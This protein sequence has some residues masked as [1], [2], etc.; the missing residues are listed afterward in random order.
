MAATNKNKLPS[1]IKPMLGR[2]V[3]S[4]FDSPKH[5]FELKW[6]G[7]RGL[8]FVEGGE[9]RLLSRNGR[10]ITTQFPELGE[11]AKQV[12]ADGV[13]LDGEIVCLDEQ[14]RPSFSRLQQRLQSKRVA[15]PRINPAHFIAFDILYI[16]GQSVMKQPLM[17]R[18]NLLGEVLN[19]TELIQACLFVEDEGEPFFQATCELGLEGIMAKDKSSPYLPGRRSPAWQKI[20]RVNSSWVGIPSAAPKERCSAPTL[21]AV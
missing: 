7:M 9:L 12:K 20:K 19:P 13:L 18:K 3:R 5:L 1:T 10:D 14:N 16:K 21:G 2:L 15:R 6:D 17:D 4:P 11:I 8:A